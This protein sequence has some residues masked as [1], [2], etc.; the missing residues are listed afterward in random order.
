[1]PGRGYR[2]RESSPAIIPSIDLAPIHDQRVS[3]D[4]LHYGSVG[5]LAE[6]LGRTTGPHRHDGFVQIHFVEQGHFTLRLDASDYECDGPALF[7]TPP[8][9]PHAFTLEANAR[10]HVLTLGQRLLDGFL[11]EDRT[12][13]GIERLRSFCVELRGPE[14]R[15]Q[16]RELSLAF[17][18]LR[19]EIALDGIGGTAICLGVT[20][21]IL[22]RAL[23]S[24]A[25]G[26]AAR[27]GPQRDLAC[28]RRF[29]QL[30]ED[31][32]REHWPVSQFAERLGTTEWRLHQI[33][34]VCGN[35][36]PKAVLRMRLLQEARRQL[37]FSPASVKEISAHLGFA[38]SPYFCRFF[39]RLAG[40]TPSEYRQSVL[41]S[42]VAKKSA[43]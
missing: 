33:V 28:Y 38:D 7:L 20:Q 35:S 23:R 4:G 16:A 21:A 39:R 5:H 42:E 24:A 19:R 2:P 32:Y 34:H 40:L 37:A 6:L 27:D 10:G 18:Q 31:H 30:V 29:L 1:V 43:T 26:T 36:S 11:A 17:G 9:V 15:R 8:S 25:P 13:P 41:T 14:G 3:I 22:A 12:L